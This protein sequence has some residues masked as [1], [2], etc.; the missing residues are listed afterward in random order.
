M[1]VCTCCRSSFPSLL[2][3]LLSCCQ[4]HP[5][6]RWRANSLRPS[7]SK[8][9]LHAA[10]LPSVPPYPPSSLPHSLPPP[11]RQ[12]VS[13]ALKAREPLPVLNHLSSTV[14][15][16]LSFRLRKITFCD[17]F[18]SWLVGLVHQQTSFSVVCARLF[19]CVVDVS[20]SRDHWWSSVVVCGPPWGG[21][22]GPNL[23]DGVREVTK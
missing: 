5:P 8:D 1:Y 15:L 6:E 23:C 4:V 16:M 3:L 13:P 18:F 21:G 17:D 22:E 20:G 14:P 7:L 9:Q 2:L 12:V 19:C 10:L 11:A